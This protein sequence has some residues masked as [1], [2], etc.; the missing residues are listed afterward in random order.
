MLALIAGQGQLPA[1][2]ALAAKGPVRICAL[3]GFSPAHLEVDERFRLERLGSFIHG[4]KQRGVQEVCMAG[5]VRRPELRSDLVD[6]ATA[7][8]VPR[9]SG[10]VLRGDDAALRE[11]IAIFEEAGLAVRAAHEIAPELLPAAGVLTSA[12]PSAED[13]AD[14][15]R[16]E[17]IVTA[18]GAADVGQACV[19]AAGQ[20]LAIEAIGGT[21]WMLRSLLRT[22]EEAKNREE[23]VLK[24]ASL[25]DQAMDW[26][27]DF[28]D[29]FS[30][31]DGS[32]LPER[33]PALPGG[34]LLYKAPKPGQDRRADL[35]VIG[36]DT[37]MRAAEAGLTGIVLEAG[38]VMVL[39][40]ET[41]VAM[42]DAVEMF[43]WVRPGGEA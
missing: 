3:E 35:P 36:P 43:L 9:I 14:A 15:A 31:R 1:R 8:L 39:D 21:D 24:G 42:A 29:F 13:V 30:P 25:M 5:A 11:I 6:S 32:R 2:I 28:A 17:A 16:A 33:D 18:M 26:I 40:V 20:A 7:P 12:G 41:C 37:V 22:P 10:A 38:G 27:G 23:E 4:L 19:V 34:G